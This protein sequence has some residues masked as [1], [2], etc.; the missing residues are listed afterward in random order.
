MEK[1]RLGRT[2]HMST[3]VIFG[4]AAI[5]KVSQEVAD[6]AIQAALDGGV[7]HIDVAPSYGD[8]ELRLKPWIPKIRD[9]VFL[10]CKTTRRKKTEAADE[11]RRSLGRLKADRFDLYQL[12]SV[13]DMEQLD[14]ATAPGGAIDA[15][16]QAREEGLTTYLGITGHGMQAPATHA[17]ALRR[18][19]F[20]TVMFPLNPT[21]L[22]NA[23]YREDYEA[24][25]DLAREKDVGLMVIKA[26]ARE[27]WGDRE[28]T[29][30]TWYKPFDKQKDIDRSVRFALSQD[31]TALSSAGDVSILPGILDAAGRFAPM[32]DEEKEE[33]LQA[34]SKLRQ[35][36][37]A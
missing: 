4:A 9:Q 13:G 8:A 36:F 35:I 16:V 25:R 23:Q 5:G 29:Y 22:G 37:V 26:V 27:P 7:N 31:I 10:G 32:S 30:T 11:L 1:R 15:L 28:R 2:E 14:L 17:E 3:V 19:D 12:H 34:H 6:Q 24:L 20:D 21:L 18:F 33:T